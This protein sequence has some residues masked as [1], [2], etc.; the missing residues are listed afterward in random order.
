MVNRV[1]LPNEDMEF[2]QFHPTG[3]YQCDGG[4]TLPDVASV[5]P[6]WCLPMWW[7]LK[8]LDVSSFWHTTTHTHPQ[9]ICRTCIADIYYAH[10]GLYVLHTVQTVCTTD[11]M[12]Y[13]HYGLYVLHTVQTK[14]TARTTYGM[15]NIHYAHIHSIYIAHVLHGAYNMHYS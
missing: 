14:C 5:P 4:S 8:L 2:V 3:V 10:N 13:A 6:H 1:G 7:G 9:A 15:Y 11:S 12:Y